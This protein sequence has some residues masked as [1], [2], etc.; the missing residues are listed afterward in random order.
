VNAERDHVR[1]ELGGYVLGALTPAERRVV[2]SH[3]EACSACRDELARLSGVPVLLDRLTPDEAAA[4]L[5]TVTLAPR[6]TSQ[7]GDDLRQ[8][9]R[10]V[11]RWRRL[12][13]GL[14]AS[15]V[16]EAAGTVRAYEGE[17][18]TTLEVE[19]RNLPARSRYEI[20]VTDRDGASDPAGT[21]GPTE[22][23][24][25]IVR[26]ATAVQRDRLASIEIRDP[27]G[28]PVLGAE[29]GPP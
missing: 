23:R 21:W 22:H 6:L 28:R 19:A 20:W 29:V 1:D 5:T 18:G 25:A 8:L 4:D 14:A 12:A 2:E 10:S 26:S 16:V 24:G 27:A 15:L 17:W 13:A 3:I 11:R 9:Q 7:I